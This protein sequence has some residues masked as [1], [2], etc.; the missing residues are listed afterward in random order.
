MADATKTVIDGDTMLVVLGISA[1][2]GEQ[3]LRTKRASNTVHQF[4]IMLQDLADELN[5]LRAR[6]EAGDKLNNN[7]VSDGLTVGYRTDVNATLE[8]Y[9]VLLFK[10]FMQFVG[11]PVAIGDMI[12]T[13]GSSL[14]DEVS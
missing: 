3:V 1:I 12:A 4:D 6:Y 2:W 5:D 10:Q 7:A 13:Y 14:R 8:K 9:R 11:N